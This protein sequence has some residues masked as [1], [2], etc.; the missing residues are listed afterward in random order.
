MS[1]AVCGAVRESL[2]TQVMIL[3]APSNNRQPSVTQT[4][5]L[6]TLSPAGGNGGKEMK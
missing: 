3:L 4:K 1:S 5:S 6:L 2:C